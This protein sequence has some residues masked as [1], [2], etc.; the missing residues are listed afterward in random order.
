M[1]AAVDAKYQN[2][3]DGKAQRGREYKMFDTT[4]VRWIF[5]A[6]ISLSIFG[7]CE[8]R[9]WYL[10]CSFLVGFRLSVFVIGLPEGFAAL[11]SHDTNAWTTCRGPDTSHQQINQCK[12]ACH[13]LVDGTRKGEYSR[14]MK[15]RNFSIVWHFNYCFEKDQMKAAIKCDCIFRSAKAPLTFVEFKFKERKMRMGEDLS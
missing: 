8:S 3:H 12:R 1:E 6:R 2:S 11:K 13:F 14:C 5:N 9:K 4:N 7:C 10:L 15:K